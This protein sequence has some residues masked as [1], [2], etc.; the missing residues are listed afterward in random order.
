MK[1]MKRMEF[2]KLC[3]RGGML[4]A[5]VGCGAVLSSREDKFACSDQC[6]K[7]PKFENGKCAEGFK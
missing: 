3:A 6:G 1:A 4:A 7:C 2:V 5:I